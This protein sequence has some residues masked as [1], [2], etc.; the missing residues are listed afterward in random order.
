MVTFREAM[1]DSDQ[2]WIRKQNMYFVSTAPLAKSGHVNLSPKGYDG[3]RILDSNRVLLLDGRGSGCETIAHLREN[4]RIT[5]MLCAFE[6]GPRIVR[7]FSTGTVHEPGSTEFSSLFAEHYAA[8]WDNP[9][10]INFVRSIIDVKVHMVAQSCG[11]G[12]PLMA[13]KDER[14]TLTDC[15]KTKPGEVIGKRSPLI[16]SRSIDGIPSLLNGTA[17]ATRVAVFKRRFIIAA[18]SV[19]PWVGGAALGAAIALAAV[20]KVFA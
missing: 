8:D 4:G 19:V 6:G 2:K 3:L 13:F 18:Q 14:R 17:D 11:Y 7:L 1:S 16:N 15:F 5:V 12:V 20:K 9:D 10:R